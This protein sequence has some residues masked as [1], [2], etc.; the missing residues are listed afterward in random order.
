MSFSLSK[1]NLKK[2]TEFLLVVSQNDVI[3]N[4]YVEYCL[5]DTLSV[6]W[7]RWFIEMIWL[8]SWSTLPGLFRPM[9]VW[10][11]PYVCQST[12]PGFFL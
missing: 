9:V 5:D 8:N 6:G 12:V 4:N 1:R 2:E 3:R 10:W 11:V 7:N